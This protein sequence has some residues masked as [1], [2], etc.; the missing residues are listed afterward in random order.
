M[1]Q[2]IAAH[3]TRLGQKLRR[4]ALGTD[5]V[6]IFYH[7]SEH[8][9]GAPQRSVATTVS[10]PEATN[11]SL[12]LA[13]AATW[14]AR[15]LWR[16]GYRYSKAGVMT[17][18]LVK[19]AASQ[20]ALFDGFDR[21]RSAALMGAMDACNRR[22]GRGTVVPAAANVERSRSWSTKFQM[23]E[24]EPKWISDLSRMASVA[25]RM[26]RRSKGTFG[27]ANKGKRL[28]AWFCACGWEGSSQELKAGQN[29]LSCPMCGGGELK[30]R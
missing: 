9:R 8:D 27:A 3:A 1:E 30:A 12:A 29:A 14:G 21:E 23:R 28:K 26:E 22:F 6:S 5:H 7:A 25:Q 2:A 19:L 16:D 24:P 15:R 13:K 20:R 4:Q 18:D 11:D 17:F 10:L